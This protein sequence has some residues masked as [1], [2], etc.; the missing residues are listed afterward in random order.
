MRPRRVALTTVTV[1]ALG[2]PTAAALTSTAASAASSRTVYGITSNNHL[3]S[4]LAADPAKILTNVAIRV[5][6]IGGPVAA[7]PGQVQAIDFSARSGDL[8]AVVTV[9]NADPAHTASSLYTINPVNGIAEAAAP[10]LAA[11]TPAIA[12][13]TVGIDMNETVDRLRVMTP[14]QSFRINPHTGVAIAPVDTT[15]SAGTIGN[16]A[17]ANAR[18]DATSTTLYGI[19]TAGDNL[20]TVGGANGVPSANGGQVFTVGAL[21]FDAGG[22]GVGFDIVGTDNRA[23]ALLRK[24]GES[25]VKLYKIDLA[26][27]AAS[28]AMTVGGGL[29]VIDI[30]VDPEVTPSQNQVLLLDAAS[31][32]A[33]ASLASYGLPVRYSCAEACK[34]T[35]TL[36]AGSTKIGSAIVSRTG[37]GKGTA[38]ILL[39]ATGKT[40]LSNLFK[41]KS[42]LST[43][44]TLSGSATDADGGVA[45]TDSVWTKITR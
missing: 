22:N 41:S 38:T 45:A 27:G 40:T 10:P 28:G 1:I 18:P 25:I 9:P 11:F 4:F 6:P 8:F 12:G 29:D 3:V 34:T 33:R 16:V 5:A 2:A 37:R 31:A 26:T 39:T 32:R 24:A 15:P 23:Y 44:V 7:L 13:S 20:V 35:L 43:N 17:Y 30:A 19:D 36:K 21:G 14:T 42:T